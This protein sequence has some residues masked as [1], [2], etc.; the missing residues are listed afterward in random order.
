MKFDARRDI[1]LAWIVCGAVEMAGEIG[2]LLLQIQR[3]IG[4]SR[5]LFLAGVV[6]VIGL[7]TVYRWLALPAF[8]L[9]PLAMI[10]LAWR[11]MHD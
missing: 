4:W 9:Y 11:V 7:S 3:K 10:D 2:D 1:P 8:V 5:V 6:A